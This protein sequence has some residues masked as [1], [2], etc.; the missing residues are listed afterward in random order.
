MAFYLLNNIDVVLSNNNKK[1]FLGYNMDHFPEK[2][3]NV[4]MIIRSLSLDIITDFIIIK[5]NLH[6]DMD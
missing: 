6:E 1:R 2:A 3:I 5:F 4:T